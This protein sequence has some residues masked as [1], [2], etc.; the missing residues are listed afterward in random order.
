[1]ERMERSR[2]VIRTALLWGLAAFL[3][4]WLLGPAGPFGAAPA[5]AAPV[6][7]AGSP[8]EPSRVE[9]AVPLHDVDSRLAAITGV[10][11]GAP[12]GRIDAGTATFLVPERAEDAYRRL[13]RFVF[14][15]GAEE[16]EERQCPPAPFAREGLDEL[17]VRVHPGVSPELM[18]V[19]AVVYR[20]EVLSSIERL[21][22][23]LLPRPQGLC[24]DDFEAFLL[25]SPLVASV[26]RN[27]PVY[28]F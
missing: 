7:S 18:Q 27:A 23:F 16:G 26:E 8:G 12:L 9:V 14:S 3:A 28:P 4:G 22:A 20:T 13:F 5:L 24:I 21:N 25:L 15:D 11:A 1:M 6:P 10:V 19:L 17:I 2:W